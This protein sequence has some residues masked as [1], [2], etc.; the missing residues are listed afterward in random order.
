MHEELSVWLIPPLQAAQAVPKVLRHEQEVLLLHSPNQYC[1]ASSQP[2]WFRSYPDHP[3]HIDLLGIANNGQ[4][5]ISRY[6]LKH[7]N[8]NGDSDLPPFIPCLSLQFLPHKDYLDFF[9]WVREFDSIRL[10]DKSVLL[11]WVEGH[12]LVAN[13]SELPPSSPTLEG[14]SRSLNLPTSEDNWR[15]TASQSIS[16]I[17]CDVE[18]PRTGAIAHCPISGRLCILSSNAIRVMDYLGSSA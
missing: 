7:I 3:N 15:W 8:R 4:N 9:D 5:G 10:W 6:M 18:Q 14:N 13:L 1:L 12:T 17:L 11:L 16:A 2:A